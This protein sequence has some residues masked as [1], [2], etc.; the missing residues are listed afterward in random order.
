[1]NR[2]RAPFSERTIYRLDAFAPSDEEIAK[3]TGVEDKLEDDN[4]DDAPIF[5]P[6]VVKQKNAAVILDS[7]SEEEEAVVEKKK[8]IKK[9]ESDDDDKDESK[10]EKK[11]SANLKGKQ[12][13]MEEKFGGADWSENQEPSAKMV[14]LLA[15]IKRVHEMCVLIESVGQYV[16]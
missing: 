4:D 10:K 11:L 9:H 6:K 2:C 8:N 13:K 1:M 5:K 16:S 12:K 14:W 7:D 3:A 15:E